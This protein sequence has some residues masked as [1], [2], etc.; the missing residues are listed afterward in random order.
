MV[1]LTLALIVFALQSGGASAVLRRD[2]AVS[3]SFYGA[4]NL[5]VALLFLTGACV[6][7]PAQNFR[8][9]LGVLALAAAAG[10]VL[11]F[12][13]AVREAVHAIDPVYRVQ[14][15]ERAL[16]RATSYSLRHELMRNAGQSLLSAQAEAAGFKLYPWVLTRDDL[17]EDTR[18]RAGNTGRLLDVN[19]HALGVLFER[20]THR[21][22][23]GHIALTLG[24]ALLPESLVAQ[25][26]STISQDVR[27]L[28]SALR[29]EPV[30]AERSVT[31]HI[32]LL[33]LEAEE[34]LGPDTSALGA[35]LAAYER[36]LERYAIGWQQH[37]QTLESEYITGFTPNVGEPFAAVRGE[38]YELIETAVTKEVA[39]P[40][41]GLAYWPVHMLRLAVQWRAPAYFEFLNAYPFLYRRLKA[42]SSSFQDRLLE[43]SWVH[44]VEFLELIAP[45]LRPPYVNDHDDDVIVRAERRT[46]QGLWEVARAA[47]GCQDAAT[48]RELLRRW[49]IAEQRGTKGAPSR[50][51]TALPMLWEVVR[52]VQAGELVDGPGWLRIAG[53]S[54]TPMV[55]IAG[56]LEQLDPEMQDVDLGHWD[57]WDRPSHEVHTVDGDSDLVRAVLLLIGLTTT[58][59]AKV[60]AFDVSRPMYER[61]ATVERIV[62]EMTADATTYEGMYGLTS[63]ST[64]LGSFKAAWDESV[65]RY[66]RAERDLLRAAPIHPSATEAFVAAVRDTFA[67]G[68][69]RSTLIARTRVVAPGRAIKRWLGRRVLEDKRF[70]VDRPEADGAPREMGTMYA[71]ALLRG[72][73]SVITTQLASLRRRTYGRKSLTERLVAAIDDLGAPADQLVILIP[74]DWQVRSTLQR[75]GR[76]TLDDSP[77]ATAIGALANVPVFEIGADADWMAVLTPARALRVEQDGDVRAGVESIDE[78]EVRRLDAAGVD[79]GGEPSET[80][81]ERFA[82]RVVAHAEVRSRISVDAR[83]ARRVQVIPKA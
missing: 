65:A 14:R 29:I 44:L 30:R 77:G 64:T 74:H 34:S 3:S 48:A 53:E 1:G 35:V 82:L 15:R 27:L 39:A 7:A 78:P 51:A 16:L 9:W 80:T 79:P 23:E 36:V 32:G 50:I 13:M 52:R 55:A 19:V 43:R 69:P 67:A 66:E 17:N 70:F 42:A 10:W 54:T 26:G 11:I 21:G 81:A 28:Q 68:H 2:L 5:G 31:D 46:R 47:V 75:E 57:S 12:A 63:L 58:S 61:R 4:T 6:V 73:L 41:F 56:F 25:G 49:R 62:S 24:D 33:R 18:I 22:V 60:R 40:A 38:I 20:W 37:V 71:E 72:E 45:T 83:F 76:F 59:S 8:D